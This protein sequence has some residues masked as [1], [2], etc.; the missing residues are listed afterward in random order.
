M[1]RAVV[2]ESTAIRLGIILFWTLFWLLGVIDK[3]IPNRTAVLFWAGKDRLAQFSNY[4]SSIGIEVT[5][6][7]ITFLVIVSILQFV[8]FLFCL[9]ALV[10]FVSGKREQADRL[11]FWGILVSLAIF[12]FFAVGDQ[13]FGDRVELLEHSIFWIALVISWFIY[14]LAQRQERYQYEDATSTAEF[15]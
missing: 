6:V 1:S 14:G 15:R 9:G 8:A 13:I 2:Q 10:Y 5:F 7:P 3:V 4:F 12:S 11:L